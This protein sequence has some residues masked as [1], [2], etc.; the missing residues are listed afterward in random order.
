MGTP[1]SSAN[2]I[3][4]ELN[5]HP[6]AGQEG[7]EFIELLN[8][9]NE[10]ID[11]GGASFSAGIEFTFAQ[12]TTLPAGGR[13]MVVNELGSFTLAEQADIAGIFQNFTRLDNGGERI[14][15]VDYLG[16]S[17]FDFSYLDDSSWSTFPDGGGPSLTLIDPANSPDL[18]DPFNW[19]SS[20]LPG[21][22]PGGSDS[23]TF[24]GDP[25]ADD[26]DNGVSNFVEYAVGPQL[27]PGFITSGEQTFLTL[28]FNQN[29]SA[30]DVIATVES[31][32]DLITWTP[33][34][35]R[36]SVIYN[37]DGTNTVS[38]QANAN[39]TTPQRFLRICITSR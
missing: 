4:S 34:T 21:G 15:L 22:T 13:I 32:S 31:S 2:L 19:R 6:P 17:I 7:R 30:D 1:A 24:S 26:N 37:G 33:S 20:S 36:T 12:N 39:L 25:L 5:Y 9:S 35:V 10:T 11:L 16:E 28:T 14:A 8:I 38:W 18:S 3:V 27:T 29:L 23:T